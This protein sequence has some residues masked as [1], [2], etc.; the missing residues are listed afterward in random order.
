MSSWTG[1]VNMFVRLAVGL[2][3]VALGPFL[4]PWIADRRLIRSTFAALLA[5]WTVFPRGV[6]VGERILAGVIV[7][8]H[9]AVGSPTSGSHSPRKLLRGVPLGVVVAICS[10]LVVTTLNSAETN[11]R[12]V[13]QF[14]G[15]DRVLVV[16]AGGIASVFLVGELIGWLTAPLSRQ[17]V[18]RA[19]SSQ[20]MSLAR[21][22]RY[23]GWL[24]RLFLYVSVLLGASQGGF[25]ILTLKSIARF[26]DL[27]GSEGF[28]EY[29]LIGTLMSLVGAMGIS[30]GVRLV[31]GLPPL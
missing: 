24:E 30:V 10:A 15:D 4:I 17:V 21:A 22:G 12:G 26:P 6:G 28:P 1:G 25:W 14:L 5:A 19:S 9:L 3:L 31:L 2:P 18:Q 23:I 16:V 8:V 13:W 11:S 7:V 20:A 27:S 29:F